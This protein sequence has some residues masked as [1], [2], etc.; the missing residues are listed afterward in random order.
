MSTF[1]DSSALVKLYA[2]EAGAEQVRAL[3]N[4]VV[5]RLARVEVPAALW[6]KERTGAVGPGAV[7][8]LLG[9]FRADWVGDPTPRF[10]VVADTDAVLVDAAELAG[11]AGLRAYDAVQL[12]CA[13]AGRRADPD[14]RVFACF[15]M[16]LRRAAA[17]RGWQVVP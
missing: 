17:A 10:T 1:A 4:V 8:V 9:A 7:T 13:L 5:S 14:L 11:A 6:R 15:D 16:D 2:D 3:D 12:A